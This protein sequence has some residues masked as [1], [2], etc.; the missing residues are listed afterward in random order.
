MCGAHNHAQ[1]EHYRGARFATSGIH[2]HRDIPI[3]FVRFTSV[4]LT[5]K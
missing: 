5:V 2:L 4:F 1:K 3:Q